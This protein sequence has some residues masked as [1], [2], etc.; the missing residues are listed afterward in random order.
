MQA[1]LLKSLKA[2]IDLSEFEHP[3][4]RAFGF[5]CSVR[6]SFMLHKKPSSHLTPPRHGR[7]AAM[8][9]NH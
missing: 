7:V 4:V 1:S 8:A 9:C 2:I 6:T 5:E 3:S